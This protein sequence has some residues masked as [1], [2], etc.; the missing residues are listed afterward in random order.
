METEFGETKSQL[1][2][3]YSIY[4]PE[5]VHNIDKILK[6]FN[7]RYDVLNKKLQRKVRIQI[8]L[9]FFWSLSWMDFEIRYESHSLSSKSCPYI[10][11]NYLINSTARGFTILK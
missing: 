8:S 4:C 9:S 10:Y 11:C 5:K 1:T 3:Y 7:G 6:L 2:S